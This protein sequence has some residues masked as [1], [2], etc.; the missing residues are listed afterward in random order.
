MT[1]PRDIENL[2]IEIHNS[3][4]RKD[5]TFKKQ[6]KSLMIAIGARGIEQVAKEKNIPIQ[7]LLELAKKYLINHEQNLFELAKTKGYNVGIQTE[8]NDIGL[9]SSEEG[10]GDY[11]KVFGG[12]FPLMDVEHAQLKE[13]GYT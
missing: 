6:F 13:Y 12:I 1:D 2:G 11:S 4:E 9:Y 3:K 5:K 10:E 8:N 7:A